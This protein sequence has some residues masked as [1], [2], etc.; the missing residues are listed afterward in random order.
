MARFLSRFIPLALLAAFGA[1]AA[2]YGVFLRDLPA[3]DQISDYEP[4][5]ASQ[6]L[7]RHGRPIGSFYRE[8]RSPISLEDIPRRVINAFVAAED[9]SFFE[10]QGIDFQAI[11]RAL[12][13]N[14][15]D[16]E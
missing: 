14:L 16:P 11:L 4:A 1:A 2:F 13:S 12:W 8:R 5:L 10:H 7:D 6:L 15:R 9:A 3:L